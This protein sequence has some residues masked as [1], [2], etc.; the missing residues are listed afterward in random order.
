[1]CK[2]L[3]MEIIMLDFEDGKHDSVA[4]IVRRRSGTG[5]IREV[6]RNQ[7]TEALLHCIKD[8][9]YYSE[10]IWKI[11]KCFRETGVTMFLFLKIYFM[12]KSTT[13]IYLCNK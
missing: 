2:D 11:M 12:E 6:N 8:F 13:L 7:S 10:N 3:I 4:Q 9:C 1:M 5:V